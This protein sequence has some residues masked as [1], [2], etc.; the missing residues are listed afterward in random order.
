M[1]FVMQLPRNLLPRQH[2]GKNIRPLPGN[3]RSPADGTCVR[4]AFKQGFSN[5]FRR[6]K[7]LQAFLFVFSKLCVIW[8]FSSKP[9]LFPR[10][11]VESQDWFRRKS[12][13]NDRT[14]VGENLLLCGGRGSCGICLLFSDIASFDVF[15]FF[16]LF[17]FVLI[18]LCFVELITR[19]GQGYIKLRLH[20]E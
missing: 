4:L 19:Q 20:Y 3:W 12:R 8:I 6:D 16:L 2:H 17:I 1:I 11:S 14:L 10:F 5:T 9:F 18:P 7:C 15:L 13:L